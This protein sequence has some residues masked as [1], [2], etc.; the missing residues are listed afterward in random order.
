MPN[1]KYCCMQNTV[2]ALA[3]CV[4]QLGINGLEGLSPLEQKAAATLLRLCQKFIEV[5]E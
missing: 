1:M 2:A 4:E 3:Q 5:S